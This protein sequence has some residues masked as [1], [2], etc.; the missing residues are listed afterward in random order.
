MWL[1]HLAVK[2]NPIYIG[3]ISNPAFSVQEKMDTATQKKL[4]LKGSLDA[5]VNI[6]RSATDSTYNV[7]LYTTMASAEKGVIVESMLE[8]MIDKLNL[9]AA[10]ITQPMATIQQ[11]QLTGRTYETIDFIL[12]GQ[13]DFHC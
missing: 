1:Y 13:L 11:Q 10:N 5:I 4:L 2:Q 8:H 6:Q 9:K 3:M 7:Q 12:P